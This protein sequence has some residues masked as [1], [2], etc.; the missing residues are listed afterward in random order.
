ML[1]SAYKNTILFYMGE[2]KKNEETP[3]FQGLIS[4][5][6]KS[7]PKFATVVNF[8]KLGNGNIIISFL[9]QHIQNIPPVLIET[10]M[11]DQDHA[12]KIMEVLGEV[13]DK[14]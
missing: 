11:V 4:D 10:I 3:S 7:I 12:K 6:E 9:A 5:A 8:N 13:I 14:K 2:E 1:I